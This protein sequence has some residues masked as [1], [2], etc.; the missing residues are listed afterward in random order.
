MDHEQTMRVN[1]MEVSFVLC[2]VLCVCVVCV[3]SDPSRCQC[4]CHLPERLQSVHSAWLRSF[5]SKKTWRSPDAAPT[6]LAWSL[7]RHVASL[8]APLQPSQLRP[9]AER[10]TVVVIKSHLL[11]GETRYLQT[12]NV[13]RIVTLKSDPHRL[14][15]VFPPFQLIWQRVCF[16]M[17]SFR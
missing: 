6:C 11:C 10:V 4:P 14:T 17:A 1:S 2:T 7:V 3:A 13:G 12:V 15:I 8:D 9:A 16:V 5:A